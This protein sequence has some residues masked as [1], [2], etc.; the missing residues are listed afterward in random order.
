MD[1]VLNILQTFW[2]TVLLYVGSWSYPLGG[3]LWMTVGLLTRL[4]Y[5]G[6]IINWLVN[7]PIH[8]GAIIKPITWLVASSGILLGI[9]VFEL[10]GNQIRL[11]IQYVIVALFAARSVLKMLYDLITFNNE[12]SY[13]DE[14]FPTIVPFLNRVHSEKTAYNIISDDTLLTRLARSLF[15]DQTL[16]AFF[17]LL[18]SIGIL[19]YAL[20]HLGLLQ[21]ISGQ[22][23]ELGQSVVLAFSVVDLTGAIDV[24]FTGTAWELMRVANALLAF[25]WLVLF[26]S[27]ASSTV[28]NSVERL[29]ARYLDELK[30]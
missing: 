2:L 28:D 20:G 10:L 18:I 11:P 13:I 17:R 24:P 14:I 30:K 5:I 1:V 3:L 19:Y 26:V 4:P 6:R 12:A 15:V 9:I 29:K 16:P 22:P 25:F 27:L 23:P 8:L 21:T 7:E